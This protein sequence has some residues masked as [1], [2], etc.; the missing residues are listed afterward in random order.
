MEEFIQHKKKSPWQNLRHGDLKRLFPVHFAVL[1]RRHVSNP[2][3]YLCEIALILK[4]SQRGDIH[5]LNIF[6][7]KKFLC[8]M[9]SDSV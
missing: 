5:Q 8:V 2:F 9:D 4:A 3:K 7:C 6:I 1:L